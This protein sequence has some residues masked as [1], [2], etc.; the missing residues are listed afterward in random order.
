M[1]FA[2]R[3][4]SQSCQKYMLVEDTDRGKVVDCLI[5]KTAIKV[6][7]PAAPERE[8][9]RIPT[10]VPI[11][12]TSEFTFEPDLIPDE[13]P[14]SAPPHGLTATPILPANPIRPIPGAGIPI[15]RRAPP[16]PPK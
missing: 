15:A 14:A 9:V 11:A 6:P 1:V 3:C 10:P 12:E 4:P 16:P 8:R 7:A 13:V 2:V 5:C